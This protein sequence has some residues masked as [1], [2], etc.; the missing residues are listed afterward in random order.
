MLAVCV[1]GSLHAQK[2]RRSAKAQRIV[3]SQL[4]AGSLQIPIT[5][6]TQ[7][8][9]DH[10]RSVRPVER[11]EMNTGNIISY[12]IVTLFQRVLNAGASDHLGIILARLKSTQ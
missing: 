7:A 6:D 2:A 10:S 3:C 12:K 9:E 8:V 4:N 11:V 5:R 1:N